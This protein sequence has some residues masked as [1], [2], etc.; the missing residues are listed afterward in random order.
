MSTT[1]RAAG[2]SWGLRGLGSMNH[3]AIHKHS[4]CA[5]RREPLYSFMLAAITLGIG[6]PVLCVANVYVHLGAEVWT[7][8]EFFT[9]TVL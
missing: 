7:E 1:Q 3:L 6:H 5:P 4:A 9:E 8:R 2:G